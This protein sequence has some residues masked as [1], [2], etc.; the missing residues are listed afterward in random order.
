MPNWNR[1]VLLNQPFLSFHV[2]FLYDD[3]SQTHLLSKILT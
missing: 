2:E 3:L 1:L